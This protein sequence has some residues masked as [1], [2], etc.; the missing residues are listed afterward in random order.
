MKHFLNKL[1]YKLLN[2]TIERPEGFED[3]EIAL[4]DDKGRKWFRPSEGMQSVERMARS[5]TYLDMLGQGLSGDVVN[6]TLDEVYTL[7]AEITVEASKDTV[8]EV[9]INKLSKKAGMMLA[10][11]DE[12]RKSIVNVDLFINMIAE[13]LIRED[14]GKERVE[15]IHQEKIDYLRDN[16]DKDFF[17]QLRELKKLTELFPITSEDVPRLWNNYQEQLNSLKQDL[18]AI[19]STN[20][21]KG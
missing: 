5:K 11:M 7:L 18:K 8:N 21:K 9:Q 3:M 14:E 6:A 4:I 17:L 15:R 2:Y 16:I 19:R 20:L 10:R 13:A 1:L 12:Y